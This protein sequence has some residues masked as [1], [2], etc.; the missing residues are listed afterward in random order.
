MTDVR[1]LLRRA[2]FRLT[3]DRL[4]H[5]APVVAALALAAV[6]VLRL[7]ERLAGVGVN[8]TVAWAVVAGAFLSVTLAAAL[9]RRRSAAEI[10]R[11]VDERA[12]LRES[13]STALGVADRPDGWSRATVEDAQRRA[14]AV[15]VRR[16][17][18]FS[19]PRGVPAPLAVAGVLAVVWLAV[20]QADLFGRPRERSAQADEQADLAQAI[21]ETETLDRD[22][23]AMLTRLGAEGDEFGATDPA[24]PDAQTPDAVRRA[25]IRKLTSVRDRLAS[26]RD[27]PGA[28]ALDAIQDSMRRLRQP[29]LGPANEMVSALQR[30]DFRRAS[31]ALAELM[32]TAAQGDLSPEQ[33]QRLAEQMRDLAE[34]MERL[35]QQ[36]DTLRDALQQAGLDP[37]LVTNP[38]ALAQAVQ[39]AR[40]LSDQQKQ[41]LLEQAQAAAGAAQRMQRLAQAMQQAGQGPDGGHGM[42]G[43]MQMADGLNE[44]EM[45]QEQMAQ[46]AAADQF[47]WG[48]INDLSQCLGGPGEISPFQLW[49]EN[50]KASRGS[51]GSG[52]SNMN[53]SDAQSRM[54][55]V[56]APS[57]TTPGPIVGSM[58]IQGE[59]V[60]GESRARF[61]ELVEAG[62]QAAA[63]A[64]EQKAAPREYHDALKHYFGRLKARAEAEAAPDLAPESEPDPAGAPE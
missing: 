28:R 39:N 8:W 29:G 11:I 59:Q 44:L 25:A 21:A 20:P 61:V 6:L 16:A 18:P 4:L 24:A 36:Q 17:L 22:L 46:M 54:T 27:S 12:G 50:M 62:G 48:K 49:R 30:G 5:A 23:S 42:Q 58:M 26:M 9:A 35:A 13:I 63:D 45:L 14:A 38:D 34:Q 51:G 7:L 60:R 33:Q 52:G 47:M 41:Q 32:N 1:R 10:A 43:M 40:G 37:A 55:K 53:A 3:L 31:E 64:I 15:D 57:R 19:R 2:A 56:K